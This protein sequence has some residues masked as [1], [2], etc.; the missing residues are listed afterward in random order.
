MISINSR[1]AFQRLTG[2]SGNTSLISRPANTPAAANGAKIMRIS[3]ERW[4]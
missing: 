3:G 4:V 2:P 1:A